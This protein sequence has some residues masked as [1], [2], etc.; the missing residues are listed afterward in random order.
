MKTVIF[1]AVSKDQSQKVE[2]TLILASNKNSFVFDTTLEHFKDIVLDTAEPIKDVHKFIASY[3]RRL[4]PTELFTSVSVTTDTGTKVTDIYPRKT[5]EVEKMIII[6]TDRLQP[7][8]VPD[9]QLILS[10]QLDKEIVKMLSEISDNV[11]TVPKGFKYTNDSKLNKILA[12]NGIEVG[13]DNSI[14]PK[15]IKAISKNKAKFKEDKSLEFLFLDRYGKTRTTLSDSVKII[16]PR[17]YVV[18]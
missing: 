9:Q 16:I 7:Q 4:D 8:I 2:G 13:Y 18:N 3:I 6:N 14:N 10:A 1:N 11:I 15:I 12:F 5:P 17:K